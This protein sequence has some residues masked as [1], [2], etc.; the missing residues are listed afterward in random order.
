MQYG[1]ARSNGL[2]RALVIPR[3][4]DSR[5]SFI[6]LLPPDWNDVR[7]E[8]D[9]VVPERHQ[10]SV[11]LSEVLSTGRKSY[12]PDEVSAIRPLQ[13]ETPRVD[14]RRQEICSWQ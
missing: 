3:R 14:I 11:K 9:K 12:K 6:H 5:T 10:T 7:S 13:S 8:P 1:L 4:R 2:R